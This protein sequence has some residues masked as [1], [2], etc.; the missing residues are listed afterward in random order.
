MPSL[1]ALT[2]IGELA[3][4]FLAF[5]TALGNHGHMN[6]DQILEQARREERARIRKILRAGIELQQVDA[7][8]RLAL[9]TPAPA[10]DAILHLERLH[11]GAEARRGHA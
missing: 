2:K 9:E 1:V 8:L 4:G 11:Q 7:S 3:S 6:I 10:A 5:V